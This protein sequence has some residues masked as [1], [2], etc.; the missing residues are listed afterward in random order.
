MEISNHLPLDGKINDLEIESKGNAG[1]SNFLE[2][3]SK[4][5][6]TIEYYLRDHRFQKILKNKTL[7]LLFLD[8][9]K[10][11]KDPEADRLYQY[12]YA[13]TSIAS[14]ELIH[15]VKHIQNDEILDEQTQ[16]ILKNWIR[17]EQQYLPFALILDG[18]RAGNSHLIKAL[19]KL[20]GNQFDNQNFDFN[21][22]VKDLRLMVK[23][24]L[25]RLSQLKKGEV[26][27]ILGGHA[28]HETRWLFKKIS[29]KKFEVI[30]LNTGE[31]SPYSLLSG[32]FVTADIPSETILS[33]NFWMEFLIAKLKEQEIM[34]VEEFEQKHHFMPLSK[35]K[36]L[37][38]TQDFA[39][40]A[41]QSILADLKYSMVTERED[42]DEYKGILQY[43][44]L[45]GLM[46][47]WMS[48]EIK[49]SETYDPSLTRMF[50]RKYLSKTHYLELER[51]EGDLVKLKDE[52]VELVQD[53][54]PAKT[55]FKRLLLKGM[56]GSLPMELFF[57]VETELESLLDAQP[58]HL[59]RFHELIDHDLR[60]EGLKRIKQWILPKF[61][62]ASKNSLLTLQ[63]KIK[64]KTSL[65][66][67][68]RT[69]FKTPLT[70][71]FN[72]K[73]EEES[74]TEVYLD[75][76]SG[77]SDL[78]KAFNI[79]KQLLNAKVFDAFTLTR[80]FWR[81]RFPL[82]LSKKLIAYIEDEK[83]LTKPEHR[84]I[85]ENFKEALAKKEKDQV[86]AHPAF[87]RFAKYLK[88]FM[89]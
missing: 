38:S 35:T 3:V 89:K 21:I 32:K 27:K 22:P 62:Q 29:S 20:D 26:F 84:L 8:K 53:L 42:R 66:G 44:I 41:Y 23:E 57:Q 81:I 50:D 14:L 47:E 83:L 73:E 80:D 18:I 25:N 17:Q 77:E 19:K 1:L 34:W 6:K 30:H 5:Q 61:F 48:K 63:E 79:G 74:L 4:H 12:G 75:Y 87:N 58:Q 65:K 9:V 56:K 85:L 7:A 37:K 70:N 78:E 45:K 51:L 39:S 49:S 13:S 31:V 64:E 55:D 46:T 88:N 71:C 36:G 52:L 54:L 68:I 2:I 40:C 86:H 10:H 33:K 69:F 28:T 16:N 15:I 82:Q 76:L 24:I 43:K 60:F 59:L 72:L 67:K 11:Q